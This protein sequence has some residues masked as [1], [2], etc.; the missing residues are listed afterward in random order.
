VRVLFAFDSQRGAILLLGGDKSEDW[1]GWYK[2][3]VPIADDRFDEHQG[4]IEKA[5]A[6]GR[7][8][9][10]RDGRRKRRGER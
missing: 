9:K 7:A 5:T 6:K 4:R 10:R 8:P 3:N 2:E 1:K